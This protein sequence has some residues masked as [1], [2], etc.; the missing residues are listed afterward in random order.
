MLIFVL[1]GVLRKAIAWWIS[2]WESLT[3]N[4]QLVSSPLSGFAVLKELRGSHFYCG[5]HHRFLPTPHYYFGD[6]Q[7]KPKR[8]HNFRSQIKT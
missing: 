8:S 6:W 2:A 3:G 1:N 4:W 7:S 5:L